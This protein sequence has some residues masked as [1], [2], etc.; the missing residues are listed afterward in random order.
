MFGERFGFSHR[1]PRLNLPAPSYAG[2]EPTLSSFS[3]KWTNT[4]EGP[5]R[6]GAAL[7]RNGEIRSR[8]AAFL[9]RNKKNL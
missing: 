7:Y 2:W 4:S 5:S 1:D 3:N 8:N 6:N 9:Y